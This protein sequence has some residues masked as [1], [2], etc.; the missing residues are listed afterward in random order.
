MTGREATRRCTVPV[1]V[2]GGYLQLVEWVSLFPWNDIRRGNGQEGLDLILAVATVVLAFGLW[3]RWRVVSIVAAVALAGWAWLQATTW[4]VP[5]AAG[6]SPGWARV[7]GRW[8]GETV[9]VLPRWG[10]H[11]P[12]DA[13]HLTL[14]IL[15]LTAL[16]FSV[17][18][19]WISVQEWR[20]GG[21]AA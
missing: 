11:L 14:H 7:Y 5:Y 4:W 6:A 8:F 20:A 10:D 3:R 15:I 17:R 13:N 21:P 19:V 9:S 2:L 18:A 12:P 16:G 1:V